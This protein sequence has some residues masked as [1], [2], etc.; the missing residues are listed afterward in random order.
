MHER[1]KKISDIVK[2]VEE[3]KKGKS[4]VRVRF[5]KAQN[6]LKNERVRNRHLQVIETF[7]QRIVVD[8]TEAEVAANRAL[9][10]CEEN[11][12][13]F[14]RFKEK[15]LFPRQNEL[16]VLKKEKIKNKAIVSAFKN[17][18]S[19]VKLTNIR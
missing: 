13:A 7:G 15:K 5:E 18:Q 16:S 11:D 8:L 4:Q 10:Q 1:N 6:R 3:T 17:L 2:E 14:Y 19:A 9:K 12:K